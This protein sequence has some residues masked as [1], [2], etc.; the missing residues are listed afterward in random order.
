MRQY[1]KILSMSIIASLIL[2]TL[3]LLLNQ[4]GEVMIQLAKANPFSSFSELPTNAGSYQTTP[5]SDASGQSVHPSILY[6]SDSWHSYKYWMVMTPYPN[7][8][9]DYE[10]PEILVSNDGSTWSVP[11]GLTNPIVARDATYPNVDPCLFYNSATDE[12]WVYYEHAPNKVYLKKSADGINWG[13]TGLG[14]FIIDISSEIGLSVSIEKIGSTYH[15]WYVSIITSPN[16]IKHRTSSNGET[17][18]SAETVDIY[19][20]MP[21]GKEPWHLSVRWMNTYSEYW[22]LLVVDPTG[23]TGD[24]AWLI[25]AWSSNGIDWYLYSDVLLK[26]SVSGWDNRCIY[27]SDFIL[28]GTTLKI[29]YSAYNT[30][31]ANHVGYATATISGGLKTETTKIKYFSAVISGHTYR[32]DETNYTVPLSVPEGSTLTGFSV[33]YFLNKAYASSSDE[34]LAKSRVNCTLKNPIGDISWQGTLSTFVAIA[35]QGT[36]WWITRSITTGSIALTPGTWTWETIY[37]IY[38]TA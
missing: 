19:G 32:W 15:M 33:G 14:T 10:T 5:T 28:D 6:F 3:G 7:G 30:P 2:L 4:N 31:Q 11:N 37:E 26:P 36:Y 35:D 21:T 38:V 8:G 25:F 20:T 12:L 29:W 23:Q 13:G 17:W 34:A 18:G 27:R 24:S 16:T 22:M 1:K 9:D